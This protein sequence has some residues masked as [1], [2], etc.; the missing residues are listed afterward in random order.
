MAKPRKTGRG[1]SR[2]GAG[3]KPSGDPVRSVAL[4][5]RLTPAELETIRDRAGEAD[6]P[7]TA[8]GFIR[9]AAL[10]AVRP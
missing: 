2:P 1:G 10:R 5:V 8:S 3:R 4:V 6:P 7:T 9:D